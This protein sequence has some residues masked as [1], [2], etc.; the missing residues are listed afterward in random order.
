M[1]AAAMTESTGAASWSTQL[2]AAVSADWD[3][4]VT[5]PFV[6]DLCLGRLPAAVLA[7]YLVQDYQFTYRFTALLG[8]A[9]AYADAADPRMMHARELGVLAGDEN[10]YFQRSFEALSVPERDRTAPVLAAPTAAFLEL[11][12]RARDSQH[13]ASCVTVLTVAEW[14]YHDWARSAPR[15][16]PDDPIAREWIE[17]HDNPPFAA[18][19]AFLRGELDR[20]GAHLTPDERERCARMFATAT[21]LEREFFEASYPTPS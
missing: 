20:L 18:W 19:V 9:V 2:Q 14:L 11:M 7:G 8:A 1:L 15:P 10:T 5:H 13:Y 21:R 12:G 4:A 17:L 3:A 6:R 16:L